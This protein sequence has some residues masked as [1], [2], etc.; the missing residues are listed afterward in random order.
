MPQC[1]RLETPPTILRRKRTSMQPASPEAYQ[2]LHDGAIALA[3]AETY[4]IRVDT[5][6]LQR[7]IKKTDRR[8]KRMGD[9]LRRDEVWRLW[10]KRY[11][12]KSKLTNRNQLADIVFNKLGYERR[13][14]KVD[15]SAFE[16]VDHPFVRDFIELMKWNKVKGTYLEGIERETVDGRLHPFFNLN[17]ARTYRSSSDKPN[18]QNYPIRNPKYAKIIRSCFIADDD[19]SV[20]V[21]VD[22][23]GIEVRIAACYHKDPTMLSYI[24]DPT[25]DMHRDM[26]AQC[27]KLKPEQV[28]KEVRYCGK[29]MFVFPEFYGDYYV[30][31]AKHMWEAIDR[32]DLQTPEGLGLKQHLEG[33]GI[34]GLGKCDPEERAIPGTF[35]HHLQAVEKD[36]W[37]RR[38][39][40]YASWKK[41]WYNKYLR[42]GSFKM[43][44][45]FSVNGVL[46][47]ND[48]INYP[49]QGAA[50]HCLLWSLITLDKRL[51]KYKMKSRIVGQI[52]DSIV[53]N[54]KVAELD[55]FLE[56][57][58]HIM[59]VE[60]P[61]L[62]KWIIVPLE[63]EAEA[64]PP[65]GN[66]FEKEKVKL[67]A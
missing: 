6:F 27:Y 40:V 67:A 29:N 7:A 17:T 49:V 57:A 30:H 62:W 34:T 31:C 65:G 5:K 63:V 18:F 14:K 52:H 51:R 50:F 39:N 42:T 59:T 32:M 16:H 19:D 2:L 45:G 58:H 23:G 11:G 53:A 22:Y 44:S 9:R 64:T 15:E 56:M 33:Q 66:W 61:K 60:L 46:K 38:F 35:E 24:N 10:K 13:S 36:F 8:L 12:D 3:R 43:L 26:A 47:K 21:E 48:V 28:S 20:L 41:S 25:K 4:G 1:A 37:G 55:Q 54:V